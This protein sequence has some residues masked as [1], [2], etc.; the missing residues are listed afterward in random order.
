MQNQEFTELYDQYVDRVYSFVYRRVSHKQTAEDLTSQTFIKAWE[1]INKFNSS[2]GAFSSWIFT[3]AKNNIIDHYRKHKENY[4]L[5]NFFDLSS[6]EDVEK[7]SGLRHELEQ[8]KKYLDQLSPEQKEI[9]IMRVWDDLSFKD[10]AEILS[11]NEAAVK[12]NFYRGMQKLQKEFAVVAM[13][14]LIT[15]GF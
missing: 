15:K 3:I 11:K 2:K 10:I 8:I 4:A 7:Q 6:G 9:I 5:E 14:L 12:M 1:N 13:I